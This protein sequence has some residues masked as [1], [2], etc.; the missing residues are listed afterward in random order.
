L[1]C[2]PIGTDGMENCITIDHGQG[3]STLYAH[4]SS[5]GVKVG[6]KVS[7]GDII[8]K[9]GSTGRSTGSHLHF[10]VRINGQHQNPLKFLDR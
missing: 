1:F 2:P 6:Q 8:G 3:L 4:L 7:R 10:E 5:C 9:M